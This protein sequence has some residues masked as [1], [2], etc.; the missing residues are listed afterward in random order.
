M[1]EVCVELLSQGM[2]T[3]QVNVTLNTAD[4]TA[5]GNIVNNYLYIFDFHVRIY[6]HSFHRL[7]ITHR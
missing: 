5:S 7:H 6:H 3:E 1:I 4:G 2:I